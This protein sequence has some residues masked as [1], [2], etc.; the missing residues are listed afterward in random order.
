MADD[1]PEVK[2]DAKAT[3]T[4]K[5]E[6][7]DRQTP[8]PFGTGNVKADAYKSGPLVGLSSWVVALVS[9]TNFEAALTDIRN[10]GGIA[11]SSGGIRDL[12]AA[13]NSTR[14]GTSFHFTGRAIDLYMYSGMVNPLTDPYV[15][16]SDGDLG[17][18]RIFARTTDPS[19]P[20][21]T[22]T[23]LKFTRT[24]PRPKSERKDTVK[25]SEVDVTD[26]LFDLTAVFASH[27]FKRIGAKPTFLDD[28]GAREY[29]AAEWWHFQDETGLVVGK[30]TFGSLLKQV[31]TDAE[32][33]DTAPFA[34]KDKV[35]DGGTFT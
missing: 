30:T 22:V 26:R 5:V 24:R 6:H 17:T 20:S 19:V 29:G 14:S 21:I 3:T 4:V 15:V 11:T 35:W 1:A 23:G 2:V 25:L 7:V 27:G 13:V 12:G 34:A 8:A 16:T 33:K 31:H 9:K 32:L 28:P 10:L 18:W